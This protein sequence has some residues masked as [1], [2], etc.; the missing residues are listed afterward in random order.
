MDYRVHD[1]NTMSAA[2]TARDFLPAVER[3][4]NDRLVSTRL[5][6]K[7]VPALRRMA[8]VHL[9]IYAAAQAVRFR[10]Y[11]TA[12]SYLSVVGRKSPLAVPR[13]IT[14]VGLAYFGT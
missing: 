3:I 14:T 9:M 5:P 1:A 6:A 11:A 12:L 7:L 8:E 2:R 4:F 13:A 10:R